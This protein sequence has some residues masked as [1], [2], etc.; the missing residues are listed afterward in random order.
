[1]IW[2]KI[3]GFLTAG[4]VGIA[5]AG[6]LNQTAV[7]TPLNSR[8][9]AFSEDFSLKAVYSPIESLTGPIIRCES[10]GDPKA[11]GDNG[12][13]FNQYQF[14]QRTFFDYGKKYKILP[15]DLEFAETLNIIQDGEIAE[16]IAM[17]MI[18]NEKNRALAHWSCAGIENVKWQE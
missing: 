2:H 1:M 3:A 15:E 18:Q 12:K 14:H 9:P 16:R 6:N 11:I 17:A 7:S 8:N 4:L 5:L 10:A 13:A